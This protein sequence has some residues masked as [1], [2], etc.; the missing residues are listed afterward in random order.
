MYGLITQGRG[1]EW[2][3]G[4]GKL[5]V[6]IDSQDKARQQQQ[7]MSELCPSLE[8]GVFHLLCLTPLPALYD[9]SKSLSY[10]ILVKGTARLPIGCSRRARISWMTRPL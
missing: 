9:I 1:G 10:E 5:F 2:K 8:S 4:S 6:F 7:G 3:L